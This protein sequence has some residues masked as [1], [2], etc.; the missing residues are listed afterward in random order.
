M[1]A[2]M[3]AFCIHHNSHSTWRPHKTEE[4]WLHRALWFE[5]RFCVLLGYL[6]WCV[7]RATLVYLA[8]GDLIM[9]I[10]WKA[11]STPLT[12]NANCTRRWNSFGPDTKKYPVLLGSDLKPRAFVSHVFCNC[13]LEIGSGPLFNG[14]ICLSMEQCVWVVKYVLDQWRCHRVIA[15]VR[16]NFPHPT[17]TWLKGIQ[18]QKPPGHML[19][20]DANDGT[21]LCV[22][23]RIKNMFCCC[24]TRQSSMPMSSGCMPMLT[25]VFLHSS[26]G[27]NT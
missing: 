21:R 14:T 13:N 6:W 10:W 18:Y 20:H 22:D 4:N 11:V 7:A 27:K 5:D 24:D 25:A 23:G 1:S 16:P 17:M 12:L 3:S 19:A 9:N 2:L 8:S 26:F 15:Y